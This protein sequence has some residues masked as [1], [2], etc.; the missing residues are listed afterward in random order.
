MR[1]A[2]Y[3]LNSEGKFDEEVAKVF[4]V[5]FEIIPFK[6]DPKGSAQKREKRY[7]VHAVPERS[8]FEIRFPR[9]EGY[10]PAIRNRI[11]VDW[12]T[13]PPLELD[14]GN[15]PP[16]VQVKGALPNNAGRLSLSG[17]GSPESSPS[18]ESRFWISDWR[19]WAV[20]KRSRPAA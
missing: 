7:H 19:N 15:I 16:E 4:G 13:V 12:S 5:P 2:S 9:V 17:P 10:T 11:T 18:P 3:D 8:A 14:P 20:T 6:A 1:R